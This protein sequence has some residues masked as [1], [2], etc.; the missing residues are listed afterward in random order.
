MSRLRKLNK[1]INKSKVLT[2][3]VVFRILFY[4]LG[5]IFM[6]SIYDTGMSEGLYTFSNVI[7]A[8]IMFY[9]LGTYFYV[10]IA[11]MAT[12]WHIKEL[13]SCKF[14]WGIL[15]FLFIPDVAP[16]I[17]TSKAKRVLGL[18][19]QFKK[20]EKLEAMQQS[21][22]KDNSQQVIDSEQTEINT[23]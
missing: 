14:P 1:L 13:N 18:K 5:V 2:Y 22:Q 11:I 19:I 4:I 8:F 16:L 23:D 10:P 15:A 21:K 6:T 3:L 7:L 20:L 17:F 12:N 9:I